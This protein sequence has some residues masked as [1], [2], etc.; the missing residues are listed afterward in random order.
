MYHCP[1]IRLIC[2]Q[3]SSVCPSPDMFF[4]SSQ[5][6]DDAF[7]FR[8]HQEVGL[9]EAFLQHAGWSGIHSICHW[10]PQSCMSTGFSRYARGLWCQ[11]C[12]RCRVRSW[13]QPG[14]LV[15]SIY[16]ACGT[17]RN[18]QYST[19]HTG[20]RGAGFD[21]NLVHCFISPSFHFLSPIVFLPNLCSRCLC[22][23]VSKPGE[24]RSS[25][26]ENTYQWETHGTCCFNTCW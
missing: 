26:R 9:L 22:T 3:R 23:A 4:L 8:F 13:P 16:L 5:L 11:R 20:F 1:F 12:Q 6:S 15:R 24:P 18:P 19:C 7:I 2:G 21:P 10:L 14:W 17:K 25:L